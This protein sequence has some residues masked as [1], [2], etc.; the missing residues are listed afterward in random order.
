MKKR[1]LPHPV[2]F[3]SSRPPINSLVFVIPYWPCLEH[4]FGNIPSLLISMTLAIHN[5]I[6][7]TQETSNRVVRRERIHAKFPFYS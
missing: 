4:P 2:P 5:R 7:A 1:S 6:I 3:Y